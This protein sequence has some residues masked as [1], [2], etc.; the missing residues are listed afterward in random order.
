MRNDRNDQLRRVIVGVDDRRG[1]V[2]T[3]RCAAEEARRRRA[4]LV[5]VTVWSPFG[6][7]VAERAYPCPELDAS[8]KASAQHMLDTACERA[9]LPGG[10]PVE[11]RVE[12]GLLGPVL[13]DLAHGPQDLLVVGLRYRQAFAWLRPSAD[14][15][16]LRK[17]AAPVLIVPPDWAC[18]AGAP[19][20]AF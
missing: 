17:A 4:V 13:A 3:L 7:D 15:Y 11:R 18:G 12:R 6:G 2:V 1:S 5:A 8:Q 10:L 14:R 16:C 9:G 19:A 20:P